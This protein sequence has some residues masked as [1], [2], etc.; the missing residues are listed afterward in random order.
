MAGNST[1]PHVCVYFEDSDVEPL[2]VCGER[3]LIVVD[4]ETG[5]AY[6]VPLDSPPSRSTDDTSSDRTQRELALSA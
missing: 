6:L 1:H 4:E 3:A 2:C 5:E